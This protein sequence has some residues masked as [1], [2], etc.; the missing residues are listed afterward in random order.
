MRLWTIWDPKHP[1][2]LAVVAG[3]P[4]VISAQLSSSHERDFRPWSLVP[5][6][7]NTRCPMSNHHGAPLGGAYQLGCL[8]TLSEKW[9]CLIRAKKKHKDARLLNSQ[10]YSCIFLFLY[11]YVCVCTYVCLFRDMPSPLGDKQTPVVLAP[12][13]RISNASL[14]IA[15]GEHSI[16]SAFAV[17]H[18][19]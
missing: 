8:G 12:L 11:M 18:S 19:A 2:L 15:G 10:K 4:P 1:T 7:G 16:L 9:S 6:L 3:W 17:S 5:H 14:E 13:P